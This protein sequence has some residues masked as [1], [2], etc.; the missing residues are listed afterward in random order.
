MARP[1]AGPRSRQAGRRTLLWRRATPP[2]TLHTTS[3]AWDV[4]QKTIDE[5]YLIW[6]L[7]G[8]MDMI[9]EIDEGLY[10]ILTEIMEDT[11]IEKGY[12]V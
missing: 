7:T 1:L 2:E 3:L 4:S 11:L 9:K 8:V 6:H 5:L 10:D 12:E